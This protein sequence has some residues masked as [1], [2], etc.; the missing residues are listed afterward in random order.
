MNDKVGGSVEDVDG[1]GEVGIFGSFSAEE[2]A[3]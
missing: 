2:E 1:G 3:S